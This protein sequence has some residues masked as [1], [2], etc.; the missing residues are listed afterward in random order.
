[1]GLSECDSEDP[2]D[3]TDL[4][5]MENRIDNFLD[6]EGV[7][8]GDVNDAKQALLDKCTTLPK[9][10][11]SLPPSGRQ[12]FINR[13]LGFNLSG[14]KLFRARLSKPPQNFVEASFGAAQR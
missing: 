8:V 6:S 3:D 13:K 1:M 4:F 11:L 10:T 14:S 9:V 5:A 7:F 2:T 12:S